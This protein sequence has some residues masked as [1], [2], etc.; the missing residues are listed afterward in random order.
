MVRSAFAQEKNI[1]DC[2]AKVF[3]SNALRVKISFIKVGGVAS[4]QI[5]CVVYCGASS[6]ALLLPEK[7]AAV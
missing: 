4:T 3:A 1:F 5:G 7:G 6:P 2:F